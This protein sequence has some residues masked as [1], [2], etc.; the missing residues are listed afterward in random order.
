MKG[1][2]IH[3]S[4]QTVDKVRHIRAGFFCLIEPKVLDFKDFEVLFWY[5]KSIKK[6]GGNTYDDT[7]C[8]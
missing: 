3:N 4:L 7:E 1:N 2:C 6:G 5:N 8:G